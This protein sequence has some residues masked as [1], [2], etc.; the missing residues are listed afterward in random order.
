MKHTHNHGED[1][2]QQKKD[3]VLKGTQEK[4]K[5]TKNKHNVEVKTSNQPIF[6]RTALEEKLIAFSANTDMILTDSDSDADTPSKQNDDNQSTV[7][8][9]QLLPCEE[10][11]KS[12]QNNSV[13]GSSCTIDMT[14]SS[15]STYK[16]TEVISDDKMLAICE[17]LEEKDKPKAIVI[18]DSED[19]LLQEIKDENNDRLSNACKE[20]R[21]KEIL[22]LPPK[23]SVGMTMNYSETCD[24]I[25]VDT[26]ELHE[27]KTG[28]PNEKIE[29]Q[30]K[31]L[32][33]KKLI[34]MIEDLQ[35]C[36]AG[37]HFI[38]KS[39]KEDAKIKKSKKKEKNKPD[40]SKLADVDFFAADVSKLK[41]KMT[42]KEGKHV[43]KSKHKIIS[44]SDKKKMKKKLGE[45][46]LAPVKEKSK[47]Q[48]Y[49]ELKRLFKDSENTLDK[50]ED[51]Q[52]K[53]L[54]VDNKFV[55]TLEKEKETIRPSDFLLKKPKHSW[56]NESKGFKKDKD[57]SKSNVH[58]N[59]DETTEEKQSSKNPFVLVAPDKKVIL[60]PDNDTVCENSQYADALG[61]SDTN[62]H[63]DYSG[64]DEDS[65]ENELLRIFNDYN[66]DNDEPE[67][68]D[69]VDDLLINIDVVNVRDSDDKKEKKLVQS[70][71]SISGLKRQ[72]S[73]GTSAA[74]KKQRVAHQPNLASYFIY[75][76][77]LCMVI[78]V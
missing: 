10:K 72:S 67:M 25:F 73:E 58:N 63:S 59:A 14:T 51:Q 33:G 68:N 1:V 56:K 57:D 50:L 32:Q 37:S 4:T 19:E 76:F 48:R 24:E 15:V 70:S 45:S 78:N 29:E 66:P 6:K 54:L 20:S 12:F 7:S 23:S 49:K 44:E 27:N 46:N 31:G 16:S 18:S 2:K 36:G 60:I 77:L 55:A 3:L 30:V 21:T 11:G 65:E 64:L 69:C 8:K 74:F 13:K 35:N 52:K 62:R 34:V 71:K 43:E 17:K 42:A 38:L 61:T 5:T 26:E 39:T 9:P 28:K 40:S 47:I 22:E 41:K 75:I 53:S